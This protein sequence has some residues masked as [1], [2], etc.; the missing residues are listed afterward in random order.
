MAAYAYVAN[1]GDSTVTKINLST[2]LTVGSALAVGSGPYSIAI[3]P[4]GTYAYTANYT[5]STVT[6]INLS[7]FL[8]VGS[9]LA[10]GTGPRA[11]AI[12]IA[13][14]S[15]VPPASQPSFVPQIRASCYHHK[16]WRQRGSG[17]LTRG[18]G[19][20]RAT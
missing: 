9:A 8:T 12:A 20:A 2:F 18:D 17:L 14:S 11:I 19:L 4:T 7:T 15:Y 1:E 16:P 3:D 13:P 5:A 6:K 10:V